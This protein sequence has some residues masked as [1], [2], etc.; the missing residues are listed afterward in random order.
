MINSESNDNIRLL[1]R[2]MVSNM[3]DEM[4]GDGYVD[5]RKLTAA[6]E[7]KKEELV[8]ALK[9]KYGKTPKTYAI[10]TAKAKELAEDHYF[11]DSDKEDEKKENGKEGEI[12]KPR[13]GINASSKYLA[14][15]YKDGEVD[16]NKYFDTEEEAQEWIDDCCNESEITEVNFTKKYDD[17]EHLTPKQKKLPDEVQKGI[18]DKESNIDEDIEEI[19]NLSHNAKRVAGSMG[20]E[21]LPYHAPMM[22]NEEEKEGF[23]KKYD[24]N[25]ALV[26]KQ[27]TNLPDDIQAMIIKSKEGKNEEKDIDEKSLS[28]SYLKSSRATPKEKQ[29]IKKG[30]HSLE[31]SK[32]QDSE[33]LKLVESIIKEIESED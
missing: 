25:S 29:Q 15:V 5:E 16:D 3:M 8:K 7:K 2:E 30:Y 23:S 27:R 26:K 22:T 24:D 18:I 14:I 33:E 13:F 21:N 9:P 6:E 11:F 10:A 28:F 20:K 19:R 4:P 12:L 31:E 17:S 32:F 1:I